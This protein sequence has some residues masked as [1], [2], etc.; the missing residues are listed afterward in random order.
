VKWE[1]VNGRSFSF[2]SDIDNEEFD[3]VHSSS[4][5]SDSSGDKSRDTL[6]SESSTRSV[7]V[8]VAAFAILK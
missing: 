2:G 8:F 6:T 3:V 7:S 1:F 4:T 5:D